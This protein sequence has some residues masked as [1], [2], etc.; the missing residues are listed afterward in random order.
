[1]VLAAGRG[2]RLGALTANVP[3]PLVEVGGRPVL[4]WTLEWLAAA[5]A[6]EVWLNLHHRGER[7]QAAIG[8]GRRFGLSVRY[9]PEATLLG[10]AG[11]WR[12]VT[13]Q[14]PWR[15]WLVVYGDN[16][17]RFD[18]AALVRTHRAAGPGTVATIALFDPARHAN[19]GVAGGH[20]RLGADGGVLGFVEGDPSSEGGLVNAGAYVL[21]ASIAQEVPQDPADFGRDVLPRLAAAGRLRGHVLEAGAFCLGVD[22]PGALAR[23]RA[24]LATAEVA[25]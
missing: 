21:D 19:T 13:E 3:K 14:A 2:T 7:I 18:L 16:L 8:D 25:P 5:G 23:A 15:R 6:R 20:A 17:M 9:S 10:T 4:E 12:R 11:G 24:L 1:M 22:L